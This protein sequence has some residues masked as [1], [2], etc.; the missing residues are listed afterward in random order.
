MMVATERPKRKNAGSKM[1]AMVSKEKENDNDDFNNS[2]EVT[3]NNTKVIIEPMI[4]KMN[5]ILVFF[6][7]QIY[8]M[9]KIL[10]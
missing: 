5:L 1:T 3:T 10:V 8:Q 4:M 7:H 6:Q 2:S 9:R